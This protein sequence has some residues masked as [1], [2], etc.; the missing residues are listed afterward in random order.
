[1][2]SD[3]A[4][5]GRML[6]LAGVLMA[7]GVMGEWVLGPQRPDGSVVRPGVFAA[8]VAAT[9]VGWGL[10]GVAARRLRRVAVTETRGVRV[11]A[12]LLLVG[13]VLLVIGGVAV[14]STGLVTGTPAGA[15]FVAFGLGMLL[16]AAGAI[17]VG[18]AY[19]RQSPVGGA[20]LLLLLA[21]AASLV[22]IVAPVDRVHEASMAA[23]F[24]GWSLLGARLWSASRSTAAAPQ[25]G[26]AVDRAVPA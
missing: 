25:S 2:K 19:R 9:T 6:T 16:A 5:V 22:A 15:S 18:I 4:A 10:L 14:M 3:V 7:L 17:T 21:G 11:G 23:S 13:A 8:L 1:M 20:W 26:G 12:R 24:A